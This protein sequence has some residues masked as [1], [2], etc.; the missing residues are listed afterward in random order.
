MLDQPS[1]KTSIAAPVVAIRLCSLLLFFFQ[2]PISAFRSSKIEFCSCLHTVMET[3][4]SSWP[5][6]QNYTHKGVRAAS[7]MCLWTKTSVQ[8]KA[9]PSKSWTADEAQLRH[10]PAATSSDRSAPSLSL[11]VQH[12]PLPRQHV[13]SRRLPSSDRVNVPVFSAL[14][15]PPSPPPATATST[16]AAVWQTLRG[17]PLE[18]GRFNCCKPARRHTLEHNTGNTF[19]L[20]QAFQD[21]ET[22]S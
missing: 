4:S 1:V 13:K 5:T 10:S 21:T 8:F 20:M 16:Q 15:L 3:I 12:R 9:L 19:W 22:F 6:K 17:N 11:C 2:P 7:L 18:P 14:F